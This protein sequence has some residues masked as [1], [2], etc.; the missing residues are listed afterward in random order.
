MRELIADP[1]RWMPGA[2]ED[3]KLAYAGKQTGAGMQRVQVGSEEATHY[4]L[5]GGI[6]LEMQRRN[7]VTT[8][9][10][11]TEFLDR[12]IPDAIRKVAAGSAP[13]AGQGVAADATD[14]RLMSVSHAQCLQVL[15]VL[16]REYAAKDAAQADSPALRELR[17][18]NLD[19]LLARAAKDEAISSAELVR[20]VHRELSEINRR[21]SELEK[22]GGGPQAA[23]SSS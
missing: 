23:D 3:G 2:S 18:A 8:A 10:G 11:R 12:E 21:L 19:E 13:G 16:E 20:A 14:R 7:V 6:L 9:T 1:A 17:G 15:D 5:L 22:R 4:S